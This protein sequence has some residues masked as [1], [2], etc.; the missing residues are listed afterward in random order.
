MLLGGG[1]LAALVV[2][3]YY[4]TIYNNS[5]GCDSEIRSRLHPQDMWPPS[6]D[7]RGIEFSL[8]VTPGEIAQMR[9][10]QRNVTDET[11]PF[12]TGF[13]DPNFF[14]IDAKSCEHVWIWQSPMLLGISYQ[15]IGPY[16]ERMWTAGWERVDDLGRPVGPG[17]YLVFGMYRFIEAVGKTPTFLS[18]HE[19]RV[20]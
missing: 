4:F 5:S 13:H 19:L 7:L 2:V 17:E 16:E 8:E 3:G 1:A 15:E 9:F 18:S 12:A 11:I 20:E 10:T 14:I 6:E